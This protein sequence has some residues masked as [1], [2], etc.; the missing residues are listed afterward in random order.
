MTLFN[1]QTFKLLNSAS[2]VGF[3]GGLRLYLAFL[4]AGIAPNFVLII[5]ASLIIYATYTLDRSLEN[6]E[7]VINRQELT[8]ANK[9]TGLIA[10]GIAILIG[11]ALFFSKNLFS[12]PLLPFF[13]GI[14]Y[15]R[16]IPIGTRRIK[17][18]GGSGIKNLV[19]GIT[20]G[21][22]IGLVI[23]STGQIAAAIVICF[24]FGL[25]L[26]IN[27]TIF[28]F[29]DMKGA[30]AAGI[31][32][33]PISLGEKRLKYLLF[34]LCSIQH[35]VL[36]LAMMVG[37]LV[38]SEIF[39]VYSFTMSG[40]VIIYYTPEFESSASW[41]KRKFRILAINFEPIVLVILSILHPY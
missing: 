26:F 5:A 41:L 9:M 21:G 37:I 19:I 25:K 4:L 34:S 8:G 28:D 23:A 18:K 40:L 38:R 7:D 14:L 11:I 12:P 36:A 33:L 13:V 30:L 27:S 15:S 17:L 31:R 35:I 1:A 32:T 10:S 39:F 2:L 24:Y 20:W 16:G 22:T 29:K 3:S 6:K